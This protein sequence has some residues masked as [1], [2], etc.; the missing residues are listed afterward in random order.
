MNTITTL[1]SED[2]RTI[3]DHAEKAALLWNEY[4]NRLGQTINTTMHFELGLVQQHDLHQIEVP[5]TKED[6]DKVII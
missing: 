1:I 6:I 4:R 3:S 2:G 5:F